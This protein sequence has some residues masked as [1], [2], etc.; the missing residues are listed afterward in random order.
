METS[1][2]TTQQ[3]NL[4]TTQVVPP[5]GAWGSEGASPQ[6]LV[7]PRISLQHDLSQLVKNGK[8]RP[9]DFVHSTLGEVLP[10]PIE[11]IPVKTFR[12]WM[13]MDANDKKK[14]LGRVLM[15]KENENW[16]EKGV[17][18]GVPALRMKTLNFFVILPSRLNDLPCLI[19]FKKSG[20]YAGK[21][22]STHFQT[23]AMRR[24]T[25]A[26]HTFMLSS[27]QRTTNGNQYMAPHIGAGRPS[28][29]E[30]LAEAY[31]WYLALSKGEAKIDDETPSEAVPF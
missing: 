25:P 21:I 5:E 29:P 13:I 18:N 31:K 10:K 30:E 1:P 16:E 4:P 7:I 14:M 15:D 9:G 2:A 6:D 22:L 11:F 20:M 3:S 27:E 12:E 26:S 24:Q 8:A 17:F 19:S 23:S 28:T